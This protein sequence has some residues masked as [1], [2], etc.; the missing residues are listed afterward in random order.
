MCTNRSRQV[1]IALHAVY[2]IRRTSGISQWTGQRLQHTHG[3][4]AASPA[5]QRPTSIHAHSSRRSSDSLRLRRP[6]ICPAAWVQ[7]CRQHKRQRGSPRAVRGRQQRVRW[8]AGPGS[9]SSHVTGLSCE[10][11]PEQQQRRPA[12]QVHRQ[13]T[14]RGQQ[15]A[16]AWVALRQWGSCWCRSLGWVWTQR[17]WQRQEGVRG[18]LSPRSSWSHQC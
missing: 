13:C 10:P 1:C 8:L 3:R 18:W 17:Q 12:A 2:L 6:S 7:Q 4:P 15:G 16:G 14:G 11:H 9:S 5:L